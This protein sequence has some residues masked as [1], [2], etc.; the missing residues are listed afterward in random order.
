MQPERTSGLL[1]RRMC[2][3]HLKKKK[4]VIVL[5]KKM[6]SVKECSLKDIL[7]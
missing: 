7:E 5:K 4:V 3:T 6:G 2:D 1:E